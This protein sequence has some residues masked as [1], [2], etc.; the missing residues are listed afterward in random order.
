MH[1]DLISTYQ[2]SG[3]ARMLGSSSS[4]ASFTTSWIISAI[5][6]GGN[7]VLNMGPRHQNKILKSSSNL[8]SQ[9]VQSKRANVEDQR[10]E[11]M[12][13]TRVSSLS[14]N[15]LAAA[16]APTPEECGAR[17]ATDGRSKSPQANS[18][19]SWLMLPLMPEIIWQDNNLYLWLF[20]KCGWLPFWEI[21][22]GNIVEHKN[23]QTSSKR[24][25]SQWEQLGS[26]NS[27]ACQNGRTKEAHPHRRGK[28][29]G[30]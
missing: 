30:S 29:L 12:F 21:S 23:I 14:I 6:L 16:I 19:T 13:H 24:V 5:S 26:I 28:K 4:T 17:V 20:S 3:S 11:E 7:P 25:E 1:D 2:A 18:L 22:F 8:Y 15:H 10:R 27:L 9:P